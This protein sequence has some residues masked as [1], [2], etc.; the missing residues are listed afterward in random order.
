MPSLH[1]ANPFR[2]DSALPLAPPAATD[3][4]ARYGESEPGDIVVLDRALTER[5]WEK[6]RAFVCRTSRESLRLRFGQAVDFHDERTL[7][8]FMDVDSASGEM[9][10][11]LEQGGNVCAIAHLVRLSPD[12]AEVA[13]IVRSDRARRGIGERCAK[14]AAPGG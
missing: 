12:Q 13:L 14:A 9:I 7:R 4:S 3:I 6:V 10:W 5:E 11:I 1:H 2:R 8:R